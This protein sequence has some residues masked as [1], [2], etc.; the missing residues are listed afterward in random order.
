MDLVAACRV[1]V[2][3]EDQ[4]SVSLAAAAGRVPQSVASRRLAALEQHLG[5]PLVDRT[6]RRSTVS[7]EGRRLV[8]A[9]RRLVRLA[10][11]FVADASRPRTLPRIVGM[12][13]GLPE[14]A[15]AALDVASWDLGE[16]VA[17]QA[18]PLSSRREALD[19]GLLDAALLPAP[20]EQ[21]RWRV[22]LGCASALPLD[23]AELR[24][25]ALRP[26]RRG[27][28]AGPLAGAPLVVLPEDDVPHVAERLRRAAAQEALRADAV[29]VAASRSA[30]LAAVSTRGAL[31]VLGAREAA[32][33]GLHWT[34]F[35]GPPL[36][37]GYAP[38][39][40]DPATV[41]LLGERL[42]AAVARC[43]GADDD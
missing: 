37:R 41:V 14:Q 9:A 31:G 38:I 24:L 43:L 6:A 8:P 2:Q 27:A 36:V 30:L 39:A 15:L 4:G 3:L 18:L 12:P 5:V 33:S 25:E 17:L 21:D 1:L 22:L 10:D 40:Q 11:A 23:R 20:P 16:P 42:R 32:A 19:G 28:S 13:E 26:A 7:R 34:P 29:Q 35:T